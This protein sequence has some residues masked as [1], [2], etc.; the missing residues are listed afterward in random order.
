MTKAMS[1]DVIA[2]RIALA[3]RE[4]VLAPGAPLVQEDLARR[5]NVSRSPIRE[6]LRILA[7]DGTVLMSPGGSA[8]VRT[9]DTADLEELY[10]LRIMLEPTIAEPITQ[11]ARPTDVTKLR[12]RA[13][14]LA[15]T[16]STPEWMR[17]NFE[18]HEFIYALANKPHT[19]S[20]LHNLLTAVQPYSQE[21]IGEL[22]GRSQADK[23]HLAM[24][25]AIESGD[26]ETL[27]R[28]F[29]SHLRSARD[30]VS[31]ARGKHGNE[32]DPL[33]IFR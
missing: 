1:P 7:T 26:H 28:L 31:E 8:S 23:E 2:E 9:L 6:A 13:R 3:I 15:N 32:P 14:A 21:N 19:Q 24:V 12:E 20:I 18:F 25:D 11:H 30:R 16:P 4:N 5:F 17:G 29:T 33:E 22:G 10:D 27:A